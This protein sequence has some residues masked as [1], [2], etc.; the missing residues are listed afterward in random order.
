MRFSL[1]LE[2]TESGRP[3]VFSDMDETLVHNMEIGWLK[4]SPENKEFAK[5]VVPGKSPYPDVKKIHAEDKDMYV[6]P[7]PGATEF[8]KSVNEFADFYFLS[9]SRIDYVE[10]VVEVMGWKKIVKGCFSAGDT[11][12][13][14][15]AKKFNL[16]SRKWLLIDNL[17]IHSIEITNKLRILGLGG[18]TKN[19]KEI[20]KE[21]MKQAEDHFIDVEDWIPTVHEYDDYELWKT[22]PKVK[23]KLGLDWTQDDPN[24]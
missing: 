6:F 19:P 9:H 1:W 16:A 2:K 21:V 10:K 4:D 24:F 3:I 20:A 5:L 17:H 13:G 23:E 8:I 18:N 14:E 7:R 11:K 12:P 15:L 22:L